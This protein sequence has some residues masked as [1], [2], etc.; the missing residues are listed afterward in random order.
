MRKRKQRKLEAAG[1]QVGSAADFLG[2][3]EAESVLVEMKLAL[4]D[5]LRTARQRRHWTQTALAQRLGSSQSRVAKME[6]GDPSVS[7]D[8][9]VRGLLAVG[10]TPKD[11]ARTLSKRAA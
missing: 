7:L 4:S 1:W 11:I 2:L 10:A 8:L 6:A 5:Q 9:L 3:S